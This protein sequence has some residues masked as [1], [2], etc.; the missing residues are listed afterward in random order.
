MALRR[1]FKRAQQLD[2]IDADATVVSSEQKKINLEEYEPSE[3]YVKKQPYDQ[4]NND[5]KQ[6][7]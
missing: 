4:E 3:I 7:E 5:E 2:R 6:E 1:R